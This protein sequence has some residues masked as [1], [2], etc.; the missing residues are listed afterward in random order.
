MSKYQHLFFDL[1]HTLWDFKSNSRQT[2][3]EIYHEFNLM[4]NGISTVESFVEVYEKYNQ[5]M[6]GDYSSGKMSKET[7]RIERFRQSL[8]YLGVKDK[9]LSRSIADYYVAHGPI[10]T[11]LFPNTLSVLNT[12]N[13]SYQLHIITNGFEEVQFVKMA[14]SGLAEY[15]D[16]VITSEKAGAK[17][18]HPRIFNYA[19]Q[20]S[21]AKVSESLMIGDNQLVDIEGAR[22]AGMDTVFFNPEKEDTI[23]KPTYEIENL[24][25]LLGFL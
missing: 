17:K 11:L 22:K 25:E 3:H 23:V 10:K 20:C 15:F 6:W 7:L 13:R 21:K 18:P 2:I 12:L 19:L 4:G 24:N 5:K 8:S 1:D 16:H 9:K 14:K